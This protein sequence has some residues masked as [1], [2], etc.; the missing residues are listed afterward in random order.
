MGI[1]I[2][3]AAFGAEARAELARLLDELRGGDPLA[4]ATVLVPTNFVGI[5]ARRSLAWDSERGLAGVSFSTIYR[6]AEL[7]GAARLAA[8]A[9]RPVST[10]VLAAAIRSTLEADA[11]VF[12]LSREHPATEK[13]LLAAHRALS[14]LEPAML[15]V[16]AAQSPKAAD[17]VRVHRAVQSRLAQKWYSEQDLLASATA[18]AVPGA[19]LLD[20]V[21]AVIVYLPERLT[22]AQR[23]FLQKLAGSRPVV[24]LAG[25]TG[26]PDVDAETVHDVGLLGELGPAQLAKTWSVPVGD[27]IIS[28]SDADD[29]VRTVVRGVVDAARRGV[30]FDRMALLYGSAQPYARLLHEQLTASAV[31]FNGAALGSLAE[32]LVGR[33]ALDLLALH[34]RDYHRADLLALLNSAPLHHNGRLAPVAAWERISRAAGVVRGAAQWDKRLAVLIADRKLELEAV[35][36][37]PERTWRVDGMEREIARTEELWSFVAQLIEELEKAAQPASWGR[38]CRWLR[39]LLRR[40]LGGESRREAWPEQERSAAERVEAIL[41]RLSGL[42]EIEKSPTL[43]VF[44][45][46]LEL[47][48]EGGLGRQGRFGEGLLVGGLQMGVGLELDE[49]W[50]LGMAEGLLPSRP[51]DDSLLPDRERRVTSGALATRAQRLLEQRRHYLATLSSAD[52]AVARRWLTFPRGDLRRSNERMPSRWLLEAAGRHEGR[53]IFTP[54]VVELTDRQWF[55]ESPSQVAGLVATTAPASRHEYDVISTLDARREDLPLASSWLAAVDA[56][57]SRGLELI[58]AR[59]SSAFTR[60]DGNLAGLQIAG[61]ADSGQVVSPTRLEAWSGCPHAYLM[62][63][64]LGVQPIESPEALFALGALERGNIFHDALDKWLSEILESGDSG[65]P[66]TEAQRARLLELGEAECARLEDRGLVGGAVR[67][68]YD[69]RVI[70]AD[71]DELVDR[72][73][74]R[75]A[76][77]GIRAAAS[78]MGFGLPGS[79]FE[80]LEFPLADGRTLNFRGSADRVDVTSVGEVVVIDYKTGSD[81]AFKGLSEDNPDL[82]G[83]K[84]QLPIYAAVARREF[85]QPDSAV[86]AAYW[87]ITTRRQF[88]MVELPLTGDVAERIDEV[89]TTI[90][91]GIAGGIFPQH[92]DPEGFRLFTACR[93]CDPDDLGTRDRRRDWERKAAAPELRNY[94]RLADPDRAELYDAGAPQR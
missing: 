40:Y 13:A 39:A 16:L 75:C 43:P 71:L 45:R 29:E 59:R 65:A 19:P 10:P 26:D 66:W 23:R 33:T 34:E 86:I 68:R 63:Y 7:L 52:P 69:R 24:V 9:R 53:S 81:Y 8:T 62:R 3:L 74:A 80:T 41:D 72:D 31:P 4:P 78:E 70:L 1:E 87:F 21:G 77:S 36:S 93:Y 64:V 6:L 60:F 47:E 54:D 12:E 85:G 82:G 5:A 2:R 42:D 61:P 17:V 11:G 90:A 32:S 91:D 20:G 18:A 48:L 73:N 35:R 25:M 58:D 15:D 94:L 55:I 28:V 27:R 84:L 76:A 49:V 44:T 92:P 30:P 37:D 89:L 22:P 46:T 57:F 51:R 79:S 83:T 38:R 88:N 14:D 67:W 50:V 56:D